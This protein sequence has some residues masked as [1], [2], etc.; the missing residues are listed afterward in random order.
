[1][2]IPNGLKNIDNKLSDIPPISPTKR[3]EK[4]VK[5]ETGIKTLTL[6]HLLTRLSLLLEKTKTG[7]NSNKL[8][9]KK[10]IKQVLY[11]MHQHNKILR[12]F[13]KNLTKFS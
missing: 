3:N 13:Y 9:K 5:K 7:N 11:L 10:K 8:K 6:N 12:N 4:E 1:M 2:I